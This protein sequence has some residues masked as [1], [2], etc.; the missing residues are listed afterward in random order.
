MGVQAVEEEAVDIQ[1]AA[2]ARKMQLLLRA[3]VGHS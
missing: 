3:V 1:A 2:E